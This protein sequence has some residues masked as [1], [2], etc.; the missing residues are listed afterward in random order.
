[1]IPIRRKFMVSLLIT[2]LILALVIYVGILIIN[3]LVPTQPL[4][5]I[6]K[7][8]LGVIAVLVFLQ[9]VGYL[10]GVGL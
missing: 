7:L 8:V 10:H 4:N 3:M 6:L 2:L 5:Q 1:M 9:H